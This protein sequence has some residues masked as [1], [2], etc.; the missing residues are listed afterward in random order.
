MDIIQLS[1]GSDIK[2]WGLHC[3][4][5]CEGTS[6]NLSARVYGMTNLSEYYGYGLY[7]TKVEMT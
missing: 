1:P 7:L 5:G 2:D 6:P 4:M 3:Q